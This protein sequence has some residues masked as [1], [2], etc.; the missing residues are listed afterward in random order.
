MQKPVY[1]PRR[2]GINRES[3]F[4]SGLTALEA[5]CSMAR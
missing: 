5:L 1:L 3:R 4:K 2:A